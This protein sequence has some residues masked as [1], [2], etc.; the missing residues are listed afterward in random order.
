MVEWVAYSPGKPLT[1]VQFWVRGIH[2][3]SDD[4]LNGALVSLDAQ[5]HIKE[6]WVDKRSRCSKVKLIGK[7]H[8]L[9]KNGLELF[10]WTSNKTK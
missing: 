10:M 2:S 4:Q 7:K 6:P 5:W 8:R 9:S 3:D 1:H